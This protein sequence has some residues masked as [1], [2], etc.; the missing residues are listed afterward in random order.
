MISIGIIWNSVNKYKNNIINDLQGKV[1]VISSF[2]YDLG[3]KF[4]EFVNS[5]YHTEQMEQWKIDNK[6]NYMLMNPSKKITIV[7]F[8]FDEKKQSYHPMKKKYVYTDLENVKMYIRKKYSAL[9]PN[10]TFDIVFHSTDNLIE[11]KKCYDVL[12][13]Y[14]NEL[15]NEDSMKLSRIKGEFK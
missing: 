14:L 12:N 4:I 6:I 7:I 13:K 1:T 3:D 9:I 5:M 2:D 11:L 10:Y 15:S 8:A